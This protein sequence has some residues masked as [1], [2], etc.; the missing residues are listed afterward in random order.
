M[1]NRLQFIL[2]LV[3]P[4]FLSS[5]IPAQEFGIASVYQDKF[6][7]KITAYGRTYNKNELV[8]AH[9]KHLPGT[10]LRVTRLDNKKQVTVEVIDRGPFV[11]GRI[12]DL[13]SQA[14]KVLGML[15]E[16]VANV[17]VEVV[18]RGKPVQSTA[19]AE[20]E[21]SRPSPQETPS[22]YEETTAERIPTQA[23]ETTAAEDTREPAETTA[24]EP[25]PAEKTLTTKGEEETPQ[26]KATEP[27][28][29]K[30]FTFFDVH[31]MVLKKAPATPFGVQV[32]YLSNFESL[33]K[34]VAN[35]QAQFY[36][37]ILFSREDGENGDLGYKV[38]LGAFETEDKAKAYQNSL[39][40]KGIK[41]FVVAAGENY[42]QTHLYSIQLR[43]PAGMDYGVQVASLNNEEGVMKQVANLQA[44]WFDNTLV[45]IERAEDGV[46]V[47]K[48]IL[49]PFETEAKASNY[50]SS[51]AK[52]GIKGFVVELN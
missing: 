28:E 24:K 7:G 34:Q 48:V 17:K 15:E 20:A 30:S 40:K 16:G 26:T 25:A 44:K 14:A 39:A 45:S 12:I 52:K 50:K 46:P 38:I 35:L 32:A 2:L 5:S 29:G 18:Q 23:T 37:N 47:Y 13:S 51:L 49:G 11:T 8:A 9:K 36:D 4:F 27:L 43:K 21:P 19:L 1:K 6:H 31:K 3:L 33:L 41:G 10:F 42:E 22:S